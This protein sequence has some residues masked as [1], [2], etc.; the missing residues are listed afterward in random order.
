MENRIYQALAEHLADHAEDG[1]TV[2]IEE[3]RSQKFVQFGPGRTLT[4][5][6]P[7]VALTRAE[8]ER[9]SRFFAALGEKCPIEYD[10]RDPSTGRIRHGAAFNHDF[11][12]DARA[13]AQTAAAFFRE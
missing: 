13:A 4:L 10:A 2:L 11:G 6:V 1:S 12:G 9:A 8:A 5:D 7:C 3:P